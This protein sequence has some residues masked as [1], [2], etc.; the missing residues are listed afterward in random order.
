MKKK[1]I[2]PIIAILVVLGLVAY[3]FE[4]SKISKMYEL[5]NLLE[6]G[7]YYLDATYILLG[8]ETPIEIAVD[9]NNFDVETKTFLGRTRLIFLENQAYLLNNNDLTIS[10]VTKSNEDYLGLSEVVIE[11]NKYT[12][13]GEGNANI[14]YT[15][16]DNSYE[17]FEYSNKETDATIRYYFKDNELYCIQTLDTFIDNILIINELN[18]NIPK[19]RLSLPMGYKEI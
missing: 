5:V 16:D 8:I 3:I 11:Y 2:I 7:H 10:L 12:K 17:Y 14:P 19:D 15:N 9:G 18:K 6:S 1:L 4:N 13:T